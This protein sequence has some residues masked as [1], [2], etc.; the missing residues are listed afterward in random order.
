MKRI[1]FLS[2]LLYPGYA[3]WA[4]EF[5]EN[6]ATAKTAYAKGSL[7]ETHFALQQSLMQLDIIAG[8]E[9]LKLLP[10]NLE[11]RAVNTKEDNVTGNVGFLGATVHRSYGSGGRQ[12]TVEMVS[13]S[14][15]L[16]SLNAFMTSPLLAGL[17]SDGKTKVVKIQGYKSRITKEETDTAG[18]FNYRIEIPFSNA[19]LTLQADNTDEKK[20]LAMANTL[21]LAAIAKIV[22]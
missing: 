21:P 9:I 6:L 20:A 3:L 8:Q 19:L 15:I 7:E 11:D 22:Q 5:K 12:A 2:L 1:I 16:T 4:Q 13:N 17:G 14:P 10:A 18:S